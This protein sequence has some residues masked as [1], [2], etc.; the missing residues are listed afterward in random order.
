[1]RC[2]IDREPDVRQRGIA[3]FVRRAFESARQTPTMAGLRL[4]L[5][6]PRRGD[7][8]GELRQPS[9]NQVRR[10]LNACAMFF[11]VL[12]ASLPYNASSSAAGESNRS[13]GEAR[14]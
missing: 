10:P 7:R 6:E 1:M 12:V 11:H 14:A 8:V 5:P 9:K 3:L 2:R 4:V 13:A